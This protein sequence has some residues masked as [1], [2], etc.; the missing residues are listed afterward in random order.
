MGR[1]G[2]G[3]ASSRLGARG[4]DFVL[5]LVFICGVICSLVRALSRAHAGSMGLRFCWPFLSV[6]FWVVFGGLFCV[7][8][9]FRSALAGVAF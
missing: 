1:F 4:D 6:V 3:F 5:I 7:P 8:V 2:F 9:V